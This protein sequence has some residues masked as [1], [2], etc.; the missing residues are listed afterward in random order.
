MSAQYDNREND[1]S[2]SSSSIIKKLTNKVSTI[3]AQLCGLQQALLES[4][5]YITILEDKIRGNEQNS[6][7]QLKER[8]KD[9]KYRIDNINRYLNDMKAL[10]VTLEQDIYN[11]DRRYKISDKKFHELEKEMHKMRGENYK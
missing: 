10:N 2:S 3:T 9:E 6:V 5:D 1:S 7:F 8:E 11:K 4:K